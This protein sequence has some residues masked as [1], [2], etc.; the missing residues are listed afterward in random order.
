MG[1]LAGFGPPPWAVFGLLIGVS[2]AGLFHLL[3]S[4]RLRHLPTYLAVGTVAALLGGALG[5]QLGPTAW[6]LGEA[7]LL[8]I[9]GATWSALALTRLLGL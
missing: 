3:L 1:T 4:S 6:S 2:S 7:H 8:A 5:A 9:C